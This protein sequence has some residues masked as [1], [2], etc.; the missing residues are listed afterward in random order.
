VR[1]VLKVKVKKSKGV[2]TALPSKLAS[3]L[4]KKRV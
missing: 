1:E 3:T 4:S 2:L